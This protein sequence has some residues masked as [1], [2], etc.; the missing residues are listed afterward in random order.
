MDII[1]LSGPHSCGKTTALTE[2]YNTLLLNAG[3]STGKKSLGDGND[4]SDIVSYKGKNIAIFTMG[5]FS[6]QLVS[7]IRN[8]NKSGIDT[9]ICACNNKFTRPYQ[10]AAKYTHAIMNKR[11]ANSPNQR[12]N[13]NTLDANQIFAML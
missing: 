6:N 9:L 10:E 1:L 2:L 4:F 11:V 5:D 13:E 12:A 8:Y 3:I 7:A